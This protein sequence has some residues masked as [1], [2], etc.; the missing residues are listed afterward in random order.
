MGILKKK[1]EK[2]NDKKTTAKRNKPSSNRQEHF[3][4]YRYEKEKVKKKISRLLT[5][6]RRIR[7][8]HR[9][10]ASST[11]TNTAAYCELS[12]NEVTCAKIL[13]LKIYYNHIIKIHNYKRQS[14]Y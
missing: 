5:R 6:C 1:N 13:F 4:L 11:D 7:L 8:I 14:L 10:Y 12:M 9:T 2:I 3:Y